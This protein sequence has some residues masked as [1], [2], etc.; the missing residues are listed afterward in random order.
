MPPVNHKKESEEVTLREVLDLKTSVMLL[1]NKVES[2]IEWHMTE[3]KKMEEREKNSASQ[4][5][6]IKIALFSS[7]TSLLLF[8]L[9]TIIPYLTS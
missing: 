5:L 1:S 2:F 3:H 7:F 8:A 4:A 9:G 6:R